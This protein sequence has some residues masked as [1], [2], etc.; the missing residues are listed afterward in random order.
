MTSQ[1]GQSAF[2]RL[3]SIFVRRNKIFAPAYHTV[4]LTS[5]DQP[6]IGGGYISGLHAS[7]F[8]LLVCVWSSG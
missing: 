1:F 3:A 5:I 2:L 7:N 8:I 4:R 6:K